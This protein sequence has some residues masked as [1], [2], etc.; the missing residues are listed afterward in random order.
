MKRRALAIWVI[1]MMFCCNI[2]TSSVVEQNDYIDNENTDTNEVVEIKIA[3]LSMG[4]FAFTNIIHFLYNLDEYQWIVGNTHYKFKCIK[5]TDKEVFRGGLKVD[6]YDLFIVPAAEGE[7]LAA[8]LFFS[9]IKRVFWK[10]RVSNYIKSGGGYIGYCFGAYIMAKIEDKPKTLE[11][12]VL[13]CINIGLSKA[14][15]F[16]PDDYIPFFT[17]IFREGIGTAAYVW[18]SDNNASKDIRFCGVPLDVNIKKDNPIFD[19]FVGDTRRIRWIGGGALLVQDNK[20]DSD[21]MAIA[22]YPELNISKNTSTDI[23]GWRY[24]G[25]TI[26]FVRGFIAARKYGFNTLE[27]INWVPYMATDWKCTG[28]IVETHNAGKAIITME[29]FPNE[30]QARIVLST[31]HPEFK[32][33]WG[34]QIEEAEDTDDNMLWDGFHQWVDIENYSSEYNRCIV[35]RH[36]AWVSKKVPD[37][38]LPPVYGPSQVCDI[39]PYNQTSSEFT[40]I[41]NTESSDG[42]VSL[43]LYYRHRP[44][45]ESS[46]N[47]W[48]LYGIDEDVS[49]GWSWEFEA[50]V[51][52]AYYQFYSLRHVRFEYE[53]LNETSPPGPDAFTYIKNN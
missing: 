44:N 9:P 41:G 1:L 14:K 21:I 33:W 35:R 5:I 26:G 34:G 43:D 36:A 28:K 10:T 19:D 27:A 2:V 45:N 16:H 47:G 23:Y 30:N 37:N 52:P 46:W 20:P 29:T 18:F 48:T 39:Y 6:K 7:H 15:L 4:D 31:A 24:T 53:W 25:G 13:P 11:E 40:I 49:D 50:S 42:I 3:L 22:Y 8:K 32:V 12:K 51:V 17:Q 38:D